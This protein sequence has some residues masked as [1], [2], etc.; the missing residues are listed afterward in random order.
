MSAAQ[1]AALR[2]AMAANRQPVERANRYAHPNGWN[3]ALDF[4]ERE[5]RKVLGE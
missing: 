1:L 4:V 5:I 2:E 3:D